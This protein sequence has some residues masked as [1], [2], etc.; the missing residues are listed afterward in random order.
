MVAVFGDLIKKIFQFDSP[1]TSFRLNNMLT[2]GTYPI[3]NTKDVVG[4]LPFDLNES[5]YLT[6]KWMYKNNMI[7][8]KPRKI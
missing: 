5:V 6:A 7:K 1:L 8:H 2:G 3:E 4:K